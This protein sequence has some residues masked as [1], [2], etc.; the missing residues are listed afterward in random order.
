MRDLQGC[1]PIPYR[2]VRGHDALVLHTQAPGE[3]R[4]DPRDEGGSG[5]VARP[6]TR[7]LCEGRTSSVR[8]RFAAAH[9]VRPAR[10][11]A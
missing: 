2:M 4:A 7:L 1:A 3:G 6:L 11:R 9:S 5:S 8:Y 10:A